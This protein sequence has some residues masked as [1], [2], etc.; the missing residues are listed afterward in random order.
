MI[1][2]IWQCGQCGSIDTDRVIVEE[3]CGLNIERSYQCSK[4]YKLYNFK[5]ENCSCF[6]GSGKQ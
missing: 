5:P 1:K 4:C 6:H 3:C 2:N